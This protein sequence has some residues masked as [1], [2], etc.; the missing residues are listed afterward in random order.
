MG[1]TKTVSRLAKTPGQSRGRTAAKASRR[2][3]A[4]SRFA[5]LALLLF[6]L[7]G[8]LA[9]G[10]A[11]FAPRWQ[12][13][14]VSAA[15][16]ADFF[17]T[18]A[19]DV[20]VAV[21]GRVLSRAR[22]LEMAGISGQVNL[23][24]LNLTQIRS[25]IAMSPFV[26]SVVVE[27]RL[28]RSLHIF[29]EERVPVAT[30][31]RIGVITPQSVSA[32]RCYVDAEGVAMPAPE[33]GAAAAWPG[34]DRL[35]LLCGFAPRGFSPGDRLQS[36]PIQAALRL[37]RVYKSSGPG[38]RLPLRTI[39]FKAPDLME[40]VLEDGAR[41]IFGMNGLSL[42]RQAERLRLL[43]AFGA[44]AG[45]RLLRA[46]LSLSNYCPSLWRVAS[47]SSNTGGVAR[48]LT[49]PWDAR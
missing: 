32:E 18:D 44:K 35:P 15:D 37:V 47:D 28:P 49:G 29:V 14:A 20:Q 34:S 6:G 33:K 25:D 26:K 38:D 7:L 31:E 3:P 9:L 11:Q 42:E 1:A 39:L 17:L 13:W 4:R 48:E 24:T 46:D 41:V 21:R 43:C 36:P 22:V 27:R 5:L 45:K 40:A 30:I 10:A 23:L 12:A 16:A 19:R 2:A 8:A